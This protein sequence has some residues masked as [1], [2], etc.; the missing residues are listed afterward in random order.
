MC[1]AAARSVAAL[2]AAGDDRAVGMHGMAWAS[3]AQSRA[4]RDE[5]TAVLCNVWQ[6][7]G[8]GDSFC[9]DSGSR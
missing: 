5:V 3:S 7:T 2:S 1:P 4:S 9:P 8:L 6:P